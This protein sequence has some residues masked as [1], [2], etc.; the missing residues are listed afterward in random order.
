VNGV[1]ELTIEA[2][3]ETLMMDVRPKRRSFQKTGDSYNNLFSHVTSSYTD[4]EVI[5]EASHGAAIGE[6]LVQYNETD[7]AFVKRIASRLHAALIPIT[8]QQGLKYVIG[9]PHSSAPQPL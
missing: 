7:W 3:S 1:R 2:S 5:D 9:V 4:A 6:L 8:M